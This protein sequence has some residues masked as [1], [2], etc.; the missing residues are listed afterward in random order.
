MVVSW[1]A[2]HTVDTIELEDARSRTFVARFYDQ[3]GHPV[4]GEFSRQF[5]CRSGFACDGDCTDADFNAD[6]WGACDRAFPSDPSFG[7][8][9]YAGYGLQI[10]GGHTDLST[11]CDDW[12]DVG[13]L[14]LLVEDCKERSDSAGEAELGG[15]TAAAS[16]E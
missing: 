9:C 5:T 3:V 7:D 11:T 15:A 14:Q 6:Q 12:P 8:D 13:G 10:S 2:M 16:R 4:E 1:G